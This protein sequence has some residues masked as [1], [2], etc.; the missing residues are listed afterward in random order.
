MTETNLHVADNQSIDY[1]LANM[2]SDGNNLGNGT[3][4]GGSQGGNPGGHPYLMNHGGYVGAGSA[5]HNVAYADAGMASVVDQMSGLG[6]GSG[7][8][9]ISGVPIIQHNGGFYYS[10]ALWGHSVHTAG[11]VVT[12]ANGAFWVQGDQRLP[13]SRA[14]QPY[15]IASIQHQFNNFPDAQRAQLYKFYERLQGVGGEVPALEN[16]RSS[17]STNESA[18]A[19]PFYGS[20]ASRDPGARVTIYDRSSSAYNTP[21]PPQVMASGLMPTEKGGFTPVPLLPAPVDRD[22]R[23]IIDRDPAIPMAVPAVFTPRENMKTVEQSLANNIPGNRNVYI[24]GLH[25]T[26]D[27]DLLLKY[28]ERFGTVETSKAIIDTATGACKG[29]VHFQFLLSFSRTLSY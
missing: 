16:R 19:T 15:D 10:P 4:A 3:P 13:L 18:P 12:D 25:P 14:P 24:R 20:T 11:Q 5:S 27:D 17:Y 2:T 1:Q 28:A 26:T 7:H 6:I 23:Q 8:P 22:L 21:S 29:F 9:S